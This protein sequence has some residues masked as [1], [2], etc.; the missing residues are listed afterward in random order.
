MSRAV[1]VPT[2]GGGEAAGVLVSLKVHWAM[3][4]AWTVVRM[5]MNAREKKIV[6]FIM[7]GRAV[8]FR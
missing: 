1:P 4:S 2:A 6:P 5:A 3:M 7:F 8:P